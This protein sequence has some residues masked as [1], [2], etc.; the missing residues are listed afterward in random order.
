MNGSMTTPPP[1]CPSGLTAMLAE[2]STA[3]VPSPYATA[4]RTLDTAATVYTAIIGATS[5]AP[6]R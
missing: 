4:R 1:K 2:P 3:S 6:F 5:A